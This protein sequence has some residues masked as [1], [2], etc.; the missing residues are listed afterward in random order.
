MMGNYRDPAG[1][2]AGAGH[3]VELWHAGLGR[4]GA[5][6]RD[7]LR[8][9]VQSADPGC[10][11]WATLVL[12]RAAAM[13]ELRENTRAA[14]RAV[15]IIGLETLDWVS[16]RMEAFVAGSGCGC[17][18]CGEVLGWYRLT[19][20]GLRLACL[21]QGGDLIGGVIWERANEAEKHIRALLHDPLAN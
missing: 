5:Q 20:I 2:S 15:S 18:G 3:S 4:D 21:V 1:E 14:H 19:A 10:P 12:Q 13:I 6:C 8:A 16:E 9:L 11:D 7:E 17:E